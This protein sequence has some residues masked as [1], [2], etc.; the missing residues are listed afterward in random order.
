MRYVFSNSGVAETWVKGE[1]E[2]GRNSGNSLFFR[3]DVIYSYSSGFPIALRRRNDKKIKY[4][5]NADSYGCTTTNHQFIVRSAVG[6][7]VPVAY[8]S[9]DVMKK[10]S[11]IVDSIESVDAVA[12]GQGSWT[13]YSRGSYLFRAKKK[14]NFKWERGNEIG[15]YLFGYNKEAVIYDA[16]FLVELVDGLSVSTVE[17]AYRSLLPYD[18]MWDDEDVIPLRQGEWFFVKVVSKE[19]DKI[20]KKLR[21]GSYIERRWYNLQHPKKVNKNHKVTRAIV[22][23][24]KVYAKG[25]CR[26]YGYDNRYRMLS[27]DGWHRVYP[28]RQ[29]RSFR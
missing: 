18:L 25:T 5:F 10:A 4:L 23:G 21:D 13:K 16:F 28:N 3:K 9:F 7:K 14:S 15:M 27:L 6:Y 2:E 20:K 8:V 1:Q 26:Y 12:D 11:I 19:L 22:D 29:V 24:D 17:Q